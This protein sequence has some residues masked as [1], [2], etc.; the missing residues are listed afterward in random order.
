[1][2][3]VQLRQAIKASGYTLNGL[4]KRCGVDAGR[5]S[6]FVREERTLHFNAAGRIC[7]ALRLHLAP[8]PPRR[9]RTRTEG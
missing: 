6:R 7:A 5:L 3:D 2:V 4:A 8:L 9:E 1:V